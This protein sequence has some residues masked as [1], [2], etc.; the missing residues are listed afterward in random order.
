MVSLLFFKKKLFEKNPSIKFNLKLKG[1]FEEHC[2][3]S[4]TTID[5][6]LIGTAPPGA[7]EADIDNPKDTASSASPPI[8]S[9]Q[10]SLGKAETKTSSSKTLRTIGVIGGGLLSLFGVIGTILFFAHG[11]CGL[12]GTMLDRWLN[13]TVFSVKQVYSVFNDSSQTCYTNLRSCCRNELKECCKVASCTICSICSLSCSHNLVTTQCSLP[14]FSDTYV[15]HHGHETDACVNRD[16]CWWGKREEALM[17]KAREKALSLFGARNVSREGLPFSNWRQFAHDYNLEQQIEDVEPDCC[18]HFCTDC[19][20]VWVCKKCVKPF[21]DCCPHMFYCMYWGFVT[22]IPPSLI[23]IPM[24]LFA[25]R[26]PVPRCM[27]CDDQN[28]NGSIWSHQISLSSDS[29]CTCNG[30]CTSHPQL[31]C[32]HTLPHLF[33]C[34]VASSLCCIWVSGLFVYCNLT[35]KRDNASC[36]D[37]C[38]LDLRRR[39]VSC[40]CCECLR[41]T[42]LFPCF[43]KQKQMSMSFERDNGAKNEIDHET[44]EI[45]QADF[46]EGRERPVNIDPR[47]GVAEGDLLPKDKIYIDGRFQVKNIVDGT[48]SKDN[49]IYRSKEQLGVAMDLPRFF[50]VK[51]MHDCVYGVGAVSAICVL[52]F[53]LGSRFCQPAK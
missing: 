29:F 46:I 32:I 41:G 27:C 17:E 26:F 49:G 13:M 3:P 43:G 31:C 48:L 19:F 21:R 24:F 51:F 18:D 35:S 39:R 25:T 15:S 28:H 5:H 40:T 30:F 37:D 16:N 4:T 2:S 38:C 6:L 50:T 9:S 10:N 42:P 8:V 33:A 23:A 22:A 20:D 45:T 36:L 52:Y 7:A 44:G 1:T 14:Y 12:I 11:G 47:I 53:I 34:V